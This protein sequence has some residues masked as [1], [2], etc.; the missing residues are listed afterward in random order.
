MIARIAAEKQNDL[1]LSAA[2]V[3]FCL[4]LACSHFSLDLSFFCCFSSV[5]FC[6]LSTVLGLST[7]RLLFS[8]FQLLEIALPVGF[9]AILVGIKSAVEG[10]EGFK[11]KVVEPIYPSDADVF[12]PLTFKDYV[13]AL[14]AKRTCEWLEPNAMG[15]GGGYFDISGMP[16]QTYN[17]QVP[18]IKCDP[19]SCQEH[20]EDARPYCE[21]AIV[22]L[23]GTD[24]GGKERAQRMKEYIEDRYPV[25]RNKDALRVSFDMIQLFDGSA[26]MDEYVKRQD[27][28]TDDAPKIAMGI[29][30]EGND[31]RN[32]KY[33]L[34][35]NSTNYND[36]TAEVMPT[37]RT[38]PDT[39]VSFKS[40][41]K[42]DEDACGPTNEEAV[43]PQG[44]YESSC[45][46]QYLY[47]GVLTF[48]RLVGDFIL[49]ATGAAAQGYKVSEAGVKYVPFPTRRYEEEGF[50]AATAG[51]C[52]ATVSD[53]PVVN[54]FCCT[55]LAF[56]ADK[57]LVFCFFSAGTSAPTPRTSVSRRS[58][59]WLH[60]W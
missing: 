11:A 38:T 41:A 34:R 52:L 37:Q 44:P 25:L 56:L 12:T 29:V 21:F 27:Y 6:I 35:Q 55:H 58:H 43:A 16:K 3:H 8:F 57:Q 26:A 31:M 1:V 2:S 5:L 17:W 51:M 60:R 7:P 39:A 59:D 50:Y 45:T 46:G 54:G 36:L 30:F 42:N 28:G 9:I 47:N 18:M 24:A 32:Y 13:T 20:G 22:A 10:T 48:Q 15:G 53:V 4:Y 49:N 33:S 14:Q 40:F 19:R 23:A